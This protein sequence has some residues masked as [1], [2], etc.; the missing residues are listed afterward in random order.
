METRLQKILSAAGI[1]SRRKCE[2]LIQAGAVEVN[3]Q[4]VTTLGFKANPDHDMISIRG[5]QIKIKTNKIVA[6]LHKPKGVITSTSDPAGRKTVIDY[7][8]GINMRVYPVGRLDYHTEGLLLLTNDGELAHKLMHP[9]YHIAKMY[10]VTVQGIP[11]GNKLEK[12]QRGVQLEEYMTKPAEVEYED[13]DLE[14]NVATISITI[15]EGR[16]R[17]VRRMF[18]AIGHPIMKLK[19]VQFGTITLQ[20]IARGKYRMLSP[21]EIK[22]LNRHLQ[23]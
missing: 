4:V 5:K 16:N 2:Q 6:A 15:H 19:R 18:E 20:G 21:A 10:H 3:G 1:A 9:R 23:I 17:Q 7:V 22:E 13:V 8:K 11:H 12:L 14:R